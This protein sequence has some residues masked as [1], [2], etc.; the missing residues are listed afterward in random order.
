MKKNRS[1]HIQASSSRLRSTAGFSTI[2]ADSALNHYHN[3]CSKQIGPRSRDTVGTGS[4]YDPSS[5]NTN[6]S[7]K[8]STRRVRSPPNVMRTANNAAMPH[9]AYQQHDQRNWY[10]HPSS[11]ETVPIQ[12]QQ[13]PAA[14]LFESSSIQGINS[15]A[16]SKFPHGL[17]V[18]EL[19]EMTKARLH[20]EAT[21]RHGTDKYRHRNFENQSH[22]TA[23]VQTVVTES[24]GNL[25]SSDHNRSHI[26]RHQVDASDSRG[27]VPSLV[28]VHP[29]S[30]DQ[31]QTSRYPPQVSP[32]PGMQNYKA[33]NS[34]NSNFLE[35]N[36]QE[37]NRQAFNRNQQDFRVDNWD[38]ASIGNSTVTS[39]YLGSECAFSGYDD[40]SGAHFGRS[41]SYTGN[42][43]YTA[44]SDMAFY[45]NATSALASPNGS[46]FEATVGT[47]P[48][49]KR[50]ATL[51]PRPGLTLLHE[52]RPFS[53]ELELGMR[54]FPSSTRRPLS[55]L[56]D[57]TFSSPLRPLSSDISGLIGHP[58][59]GIIGEGANDF[60]NRARTSS[61]TSLPAISHTAEE[62]ALE[63]NA[64]SQAAMDPSRGWSAQM[65]EEIPNST[66]A[67]FLGS[68][69]LYG[70]NNN[71]LRIAASNEVS[72]VFRNSSNLGL[73]APDPSKIIGLMDDS[74]SQPNANFSPLPSR[75]RSVDSFC[76]SR[77]RTST[78]GG[79][80][81]NDFFSS[82]S[83]IDNS[84]NVDAFVGDL[85]SILK[86]SG[87]EER[88]DDFDITS[89]RK[90]LNSRYY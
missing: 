14:Q 15:T 45:E 25:M 76:A 88:S 90:D 70:G 41:R 72:S 6:I 59:T 46:F 30:A 26:L 87:A 63:R 52:D 82:S 37:S 43:G 85:A 77:A 54:S 89:G 2:S 4:Y 51:S 17:T 44:T 81:T 28:Q 29:L 33:L 53:S 7:R 11:T 31:N 65:Q 19:K 68:S 60:F 75:V 67:S 23:D 69:S 42:S 62:F 36:G 9:S 1:D 86:L 18:H 20:A 40:G 50:A 32:I 61:T 13:P 64:S 73:R 74:S 57:N 8:T 83:L 48:N 22:P 49:R 21:E 66:T 56:P 10:Q 16:S 79:S 47:V 78:W 71:D 55:F 35:N 5:V 27:S 58:L 34:A 80:S 84:R 24:R 12:P 3:S 39:D 38:T